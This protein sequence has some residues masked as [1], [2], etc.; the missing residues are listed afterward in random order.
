MKVLD[1]PLPKASDVSLCNGTLRS[2]RRVL[3]LNIY[4]KSQVYFND[5]ALFVYG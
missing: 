4:E 3:F 2:E 5:V 1:S